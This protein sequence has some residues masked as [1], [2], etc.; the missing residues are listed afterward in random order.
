[1]GVTTIVTFEKV[2]PMASVW[3]HMYE[4]NMSTLHLLKS[5]KML[6]FL[7]LSGILIRPAR[8]IAKNGSIVKEGSFVDLMCD[9]HSDTMK[10]LNTNF[11]RPDIE[12][13]QFISPMDSTINN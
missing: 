1:M 2:L 3:K 13:G 12:P 9:Y 5:E 7:T 6:V 10:Y 4:F 11:P 8:T